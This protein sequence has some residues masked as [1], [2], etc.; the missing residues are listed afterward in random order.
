MVIQM[1]VFYSTSATIWRTLFVYLLK[2]CT[3]VLKI[4]DYGR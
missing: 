4:M 1:Y 3:F 2:K